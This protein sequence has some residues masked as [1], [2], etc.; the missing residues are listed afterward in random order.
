[1]GVGMGIR[2]TRIYKRRPD[3]EIDDAELLP[4]EIR[5]LW[6]IAQTNTNIYGVPYRNAIIR[7]WPLVLVILL[8][9]VT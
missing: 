2:D 8:L 5:L 1:M 4:L 6:P 7:L 3:L 9:S